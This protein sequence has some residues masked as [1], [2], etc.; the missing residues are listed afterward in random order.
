MIIIMN[1]KLLITLAIIIL[2]VSILCLKISV[3]EYFT[4]ENKLNKIINK[5]QSD[6]DIKIDLDKIKKECSKEYND[7][8]EDKALEKFLNNL[9]ENP[10]SVK[11]LSMLSK[12]PSSLDNIQNC[13]INKGLIDF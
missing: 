8:L 5:I 6:Y 13:I 7:C 11:S 1:I 12:M 4:I 3:F 10:N 2:L 9:T